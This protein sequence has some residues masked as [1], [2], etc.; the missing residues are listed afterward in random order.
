[1]IVS[2]V[3][4]FS[5]S[6]HSSHVLF[7]LHSLVP[8]LLFFFF[9]PFVLYVFFLS[10]PL[11]FSCPSSLALSH[12]LCLYSQRMPNIS[13][14]N[15]APHMRTGGVLIVAHRRLSTLRHNILRGSAN[16]LH[17]RERF[18][19][20]EIEKGY[21]KYMEEEDYIHSTLLPTLTH[22]C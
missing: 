22:S 13:V 17:S 6:V 3:F 10:V 15:P 11:V 7:V 18:I 21:N 20:L 2:L 19:L 16:C 1:L 12:L 5:C 9:L 4:L 8:S 14:G